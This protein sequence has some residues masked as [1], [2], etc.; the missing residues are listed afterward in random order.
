MN[1]VG[2]AFP[3]SPNS[4]SSTG[5]EPHV[6]QEINA[7]I[8]AEFAKRR[9]GWAAQNLQAYSPT[10]LTPGTTPAAPAPLGSANSGVQPGGLMQRIGSALGAFNPFYNPD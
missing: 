2:P 7:T 1:Q 6:L 10:D 9:P 4:P 8:S 5:I 3:A